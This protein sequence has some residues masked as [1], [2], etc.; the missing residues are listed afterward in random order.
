[1]ATPIAPGAPE[2][3][4]RDPPRATTRVASGHEY[5]AV[6]RQRPDYGDR[7]RAVDESFVLLYLATLLG[8]TMTGTVRPLWVGKTMYAITPRALIVHPEGERMAVVLYEGTVTVLTE[9]GELPVADRRQRELRAHYFT[10]AAK[11]IP[12]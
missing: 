9:V 10:M 3:G 2:H 7:E 11:K 8:P 6:I 4:A 12:T 5:A 1:M